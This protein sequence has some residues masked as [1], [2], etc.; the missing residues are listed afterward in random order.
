MKLK[1]SWK[2][3]VCVYQRVLVSC[4][5]GVCDVYVIGIGRDGPIVVDIKS[6]TVS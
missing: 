6:I 2:P 4:V 5:Y 1:H 3:Q